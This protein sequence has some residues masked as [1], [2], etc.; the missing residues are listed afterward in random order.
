MQIDIIGVPID[1]GGTRVTGGDL[2]YRFWALPRIPLMIV[3]WKGDEE[4]P[5]VVNVPSYRAQHAPFALRAYLPAGS[6]SPRN[7]SRFSRLT[8]F[9]AR[10]PRKRDVSACVW[11]RH[12][13]AAFM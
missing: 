7:P 4:F 9:P 12:C 10:L 1:L 13:S 11:L 2:A 6:A 8:S 5:A 3:L